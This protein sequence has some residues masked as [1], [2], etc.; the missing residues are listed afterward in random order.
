[1]HTFRWSFITLGVDNE[2]LGFQK[3]PHWDF[4]SYVHSPIVHFCFVY[5]VQT[6]L[7]C[8]YQLIGVWKRAGSN[9]RSSF[10]DLKSTPSFFLSSSHHNISFSSR[11]CSYSILLSLSLD[12]SEEQM[13]F[14]LEILGIIEHFTVLNYVIQWM[15]LSD[16]KVIFSYV[17]LNGFCLLSGC[18]IRQ[19]YVQSLSRKQSPNFLHACWSHLIDAI[20]RC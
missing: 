9:V 5:I 17:V 3:A 13:E 18:D 20:R 7:F 15:N 12:C 6:V 14:P 8:S 19:C 1:M 16:C 2:Q 4:T 11:A 10:T